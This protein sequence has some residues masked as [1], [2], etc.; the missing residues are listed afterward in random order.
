MGPGSI[1]G[2]N[3]PKSIPAAPDAQPVVAT[4]LAA[5]VAAYDR[6]L[7][8]TSGCVVANDTCFS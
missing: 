6:A 4:A 2:G 1:S 3:I 8:P 5:S 7:V